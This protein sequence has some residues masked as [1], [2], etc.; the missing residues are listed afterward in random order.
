MTDVM[1][2]T[3]PPP[4]TPKAPDGGHRTFRLG[5]AAISAVA[6]AVRVAYVLGPKRDDALLGDQ[7]YYSAQAKVIAHGHWFADPFHP[8]MPA[9][10]HPPLTS[11]VLAPAEWLAP[12][13]VLGQR[14]LM[15]ALGVVVVLLVGLLGRRVGG[16]RVGLLAAGLAA[17]YPNLW[18]N[19]GLLMSETLAA[20][21]T[22]VV[23]LAAYRLLDDPRPRVAV[24]A[25]L[26]IGVAILTRAELALLLPLVVLP[27]VVITARRRPEVSWR[28]ALALGGLTVAGAVAPLVPWFAYNASRFDEPVLVS[29]NDGLLAAGAN[30]DA[31]Y[32]GGGIGFWSL[33]CGLAVPVPPGVD[34]SVAS[35]Y[36]RT[37]GLDYVRSHLG[38]LPVV[39]VVRVARVWSV[40]EPDQMV[41]L[42]QGE[43]RETWLSRWCLWSFWLM[44]PVAVGGG[45]VQW[46]RSR[47]LLVPLLALPVLVTFGAAAFYGIVRFRTPAEVAVVV[48][49]AVAIDAGLRAVAMRR[50]PATSA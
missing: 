21:M 18:V 33:E 50:A 37:A 14:L 12:G 31:T 29:T 42:N 39:M 7:I 26:A 17:L 40:Y 43:G 36:L 22:T 3:T 13:S 2:S 23:L 4:G 46:R 35:S 44:V 49:A 1:T 6:L 41:W 45:V 38:R 28:T 5:L 25:G 34:Q 20:L 30:C 24:G 11:L 27:L 10:D 32:F 19:D 8:G 9:A 16:L 48:L 47:A 15:A